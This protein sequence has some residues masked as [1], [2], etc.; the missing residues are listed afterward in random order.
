MNVILTCQSEK[1]LRTFA[2]EGCYG[3][4]CVPKNRCIIDILAL[5]LSALECDL[6]WR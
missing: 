6:I 3:M 1:M 4:N 5:I 2:L